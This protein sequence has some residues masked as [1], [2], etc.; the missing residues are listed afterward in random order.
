VSY[1][2]V[3]WTAPTFIDGYRPTRNFG[4]LSVIVKASMDE[5]DFQKNLSRGSLV[6]EGD[7]GNFF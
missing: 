7:L 2:V 3:A 4:K 5:I 6:W 1:Y